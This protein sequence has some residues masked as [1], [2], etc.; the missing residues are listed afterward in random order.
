MHAGGRMMTEARLPHTVL[1][2]EAV[3]QK[4]VDCQILWLDDAFV[5]GLWVYRS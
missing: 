2:M 5:W 1:G 4:K 3:L